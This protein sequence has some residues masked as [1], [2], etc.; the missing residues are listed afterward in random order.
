[1]S[2][3]NRYRK[4]IKAKLL[5]VSDDSSPIEGVDLE[6]M[7]V[8]GGEVLV[9]KGVPRLVGVEQTWMPT[10]QYLVEH[11]DWGEGRCV[12]VNSDVS[13]AILRGAKTL[14]APGCTADPDVTVGSPVC[15]RVVG[16]ATPFAVGI[17]GVG[18]GAVSIV[19]SYND[20]L[21]EFKPCPGFDNPLFSLYQVFSPKFQAPQDSRRT[22]SIYTVPLLMIAAGNS[23]TTDQEKVTDLD[24]S[25][26]D[27]SD[28]PFVFDAEVVDRLV[29]K[30]LPAALHN[31]T[32]PLDASVLWSSIRHEA[33]KIQRSKPFLEE[34]SSLP[35][36]VIC[37]IREGGLSIDCALKSTS[38]KKLSQ[39][40]AYLVDVKLA[41]SK[42][43]C[44]VLKITYINT[45]HDLV[46]GFVP[47][48]RA[49]PKSTQS[50]KIRVE[51]R[52]VPTAMCKPIFAGAKCPFL[53]EPMT[54]AE[55]RAVLDTYLRTVVSPDESPFVG[56]G[57]VCIDDTIKGWF[58]KKELAEFTNM[59][60]IP[61]TTLSSKWRFWFT[62]TTLLY[63]V[64]G[65]L[66]KRLN[67][68]I[69]SVCIMEQRRAGHD[70]TRIKGV[71][72]F[73]LDITEVKKTISKKT[74]TSATTDRAPGGKTD[75][76]LLMG[77][78]GKAVV[79]ILEN[80]FGLPSQFIKVSL[81]KKPKKR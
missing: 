46:S 74:A 72:N 44:G 37:Q 64:H 50:P 9:H 13:K 52:I 1:M 5:A 24:A 75:D 7:L 20:A 68:G 4:E 41:K 38:W 62:P 21:W 29:L 26:L 47:P 10:V 25:A 56:N 33:P 15:L 32:L 14:Y 69:P 80:A 77:Y 18:D 2:V 31:A 63:D 61:I 39:L 70:V 65:R 19:H 23:T 40:I 12:V 42:E 54:S 60:Q 30:S 36:Y 58:S 55:A 79:A 51:M 34:L 73:G 43:I 17:W 28:E 48:E 16:N 71:E 59:R 27:A 81:A 76:I 6:R 8:E 11:C 45:K 53:K 67:K 66:V 3:G 57:L 49:A 78:G 22:D 35:G